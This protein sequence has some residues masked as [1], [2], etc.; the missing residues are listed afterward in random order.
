MRRGR[1]PGSWNDSDG[2]LDTAREAL[3]ERRPQR[4]G[5][6]ERPKC[7]PQNDMLILEM[8]PKTPTRRCWEPAEEAALLSQF[9]NAGPLSSGVGTARYGLAR[10][11]PATQPA[12]D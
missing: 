5:S 4:S 3:L 11:P 7:R 6:R 1:T 12:R 9:H 10:S 2:R 8:Q